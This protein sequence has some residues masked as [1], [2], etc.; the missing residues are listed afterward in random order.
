MEL[1]ATAD[2]NTDIMYIDDLTDAIVKCAEAKGWTVNAGIYYKEQK[3]EFEFGKY[4]PAGRDFSFTVSMK[5][6]NINSLIEEIDN[7]Y[8]NFDVDYETYIWLDQFGHGRNGAPYRM[9][10]V[11]ED[12]EA[13]DKMIGELLDAI[14]EMEVPEEY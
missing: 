12:M 10:A 1:S 11:L 4:S 7:Y 2:P 14:Q 6:A 5:C 8:E 13:T 9:K 3:S